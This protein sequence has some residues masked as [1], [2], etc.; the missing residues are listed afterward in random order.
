MKK[1]VLILSAF[2]CLTTLNAHPRRTINLNVRYVKVKPMPV[3][4]KVKPA[5]PSPKHI[6]I[7]GDWVWNSKMNQ[8][9]YIEGKW[10]VPA[11]GAIWVPG[12]W[13][14]ANKGWYWVNGH[15]K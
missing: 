4:V 9:V 13:K 6:W 1:L 12:H 8:Y 11:Y 7:D 14:H 5:C 2:L 10:V 15:W 3:V